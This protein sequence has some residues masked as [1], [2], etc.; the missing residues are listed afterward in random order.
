[1]RTLS[2]PRILGGDDRHFGNTGV[3]G[4]QILELQ[5]SQPL[6]AALDDIL[7]PIRD[8]DESRR[9]N[10]RDILCVKVAA[11]PQILGSLSVIDIAWGKPGRPDHNFADRFPIV[12]HRVQIVLEQSQVHQRNWKTGTATLLELRISIDAGRRLEKP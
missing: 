4:D 6:A 8:L 1:M 3:L 7:Y 12:R 5:R 9:V 2:P 11:P 10:A